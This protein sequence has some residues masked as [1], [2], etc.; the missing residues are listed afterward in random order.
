LAYQEERH[1]TTFERLM[2]KAPTSETPAATSAAYEEYLQVA[3]QNALFAGPDKGLALAKEAKDEESALR[4]AIAFEKDTLLFFYD[5]R[6]MVPD[7]Q[8]DA[9]VAIIEEERKHV[10]QLVG[11]LKDRPWVS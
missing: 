6:D 7:E 11:V 2:D 4:A 9:I 10:R 3:L 8:K 5:L 1:Y